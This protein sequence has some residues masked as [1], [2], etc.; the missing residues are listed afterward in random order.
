MPDAPAF[1]VPNATP[2]NQEGLYASFAQRCGCAVPVPGKRI[3]SIRYV[4]DGV[5]WT[6][7]VGQELHGVKQVTSRS[8]GKKMV[9]TVQTSDPATVLA[10]FDG[11]PCFLVVTNHRIPINV[12]SRWENPFLAGRPLEVTYFSAKQE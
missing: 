6:A 5:E 3:F 11:V 12:G 9:R 8:R 2:E 10:I 7:T 1:F 4:H